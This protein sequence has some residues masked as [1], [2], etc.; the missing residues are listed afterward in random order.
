MASP[1]AAIAFLRY[2]T[3]EE[4][5][6]M[7]Q[8]PKYFEAVALRGLRDFRAERGRLQCAMEVSLEK[9]NRMGNL[10]GGQLPTML[11]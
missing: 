9:Q 5:K 11:C 6:D 7:I 2:M 10:H 1:A 8:G 3:S 4:R